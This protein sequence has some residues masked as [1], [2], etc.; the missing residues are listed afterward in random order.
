M[1]ILAH[2]GLWYTPDE[3]NSREAFRR[4]FRLGFGA[5]TDVRD[6]NGSL[7][8]SHDMPVTG[9]LP[10]E[11]VLDDYRRA[12]KPGW[13]ALNLKADGLAVPLKALLTRY[14]I[15]R[16]FCFDMSVPD[17]LSCLRNGLI[18]A[19]RI[20]EYEQEGPLCALTSAVW[21][22]GFPPR[23]P[24]ASQLQRWLTSGKPVCLVSPE[25]HGHPADAFLAAVSMLPE[26]VRHHPELMLCTDHP[27]H[28]Q[29]TLKCTK[30]TV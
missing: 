12:G 1:H 3:K 29:R 4:A 11:V 8:V 20:S 28:A 13:L 14:E 24:D 18:T 5:E 6:L 27:R 25:L 30:S 26:A 2:R 17:T 7:V 15:E 22:D 23:Q 16:Y 21:L 10:L 19:A 9:A